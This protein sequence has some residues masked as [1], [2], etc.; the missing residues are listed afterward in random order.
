MKN[1]NIP[2]TIDELISKATEA[3]TKSKLGGNA[4]VCL[5]E[6]GREYVEFVDAKLDEDPTDDGVGGVFILKLMTD[7]K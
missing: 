7:I 3:K 2:L 6:Y 4:I 5:C 1:T